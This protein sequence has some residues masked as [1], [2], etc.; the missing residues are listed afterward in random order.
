MDKY[1]TANHALE[2]PERL[3]AKPFCTSSSNSLRTASF[4][5]ADDALANSL[6]E[7]SRRNLTKKAPEVAIDVKLALKI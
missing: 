3:A 6:R 4:N 7:N 1:Q 5:D 2:V